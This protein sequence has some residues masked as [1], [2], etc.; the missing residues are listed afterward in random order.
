[1]AAYTQAQL[2]AIR[3]AYASGVT[4]VTH[5]GMTTEYRSREDMRRIIAE[6][7]AELA[8]EATG[9]GQPV[10]GFAAFKRA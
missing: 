9:R 10:A 2:D 4:R 1:M 5:D 6:I 8:A 7:E 3:R